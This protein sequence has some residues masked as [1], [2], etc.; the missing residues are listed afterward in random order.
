LLTGCSSF[1]TR[2]LQIIELEGINGNL[3]GSKNSFSNVEIN[4]GYALTKRTERRLVLYHLT[5]NAVYSNLVEGQ[6][7]YEN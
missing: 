4:E 7:N 2:I 3:L 5:K 1:S 6:G